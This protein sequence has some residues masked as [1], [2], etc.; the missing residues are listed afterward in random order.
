MTS[1]ETPPS[2]TACWMAMRASRGICDAWHQLAIVAAVDEQA[3]G[4]SLLEERG[5]DLLGGDVRGYRQ[6]RRATAVSVVEPLDQVRVPW[7]AAPG[8]DGESTG[9]LS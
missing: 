1:T 7:S 5:A 9:E 6:H 8:A 4:M 2:P 3:L